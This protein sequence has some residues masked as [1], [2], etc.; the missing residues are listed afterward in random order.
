MPYV[1]DYSMKKEKQDLVELEECPYDHT[2]NAKML[3]AIADARK[4][5]GLHRC[6][7]AYDL[8]EQC[9]IKVKRAQK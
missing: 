6:K 4:G 2:P 5:I 3:K 9:G 8:F 7:D 1:K